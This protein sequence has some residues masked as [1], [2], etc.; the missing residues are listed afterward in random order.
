MDPTPGA[1]VYDP[2]QFPPRAV[3]VDIVVFSVRHDAP[4]PGEGRPDDRLQVLVID[5]SSDAEVFPGLLALPGSFVRDDENLIQAAARV[6]R[7]KADLEL[8]LTALEQFGA[9]GDPDR[10]PRMR[11]IS[12]GFIAR[13]DAAMVAVDEIIR[14]IAAGW[15]WVPVV[16]LIDRDDRS[17]AFDHAQILREA[18][19]Y[20]RTGVE[21]TD[22][23]LDLLPEQ[24]T[25]KQLRSTYEAIWGA[26]IDA[27]NFAKRVARLDGFIEECE[28]PEQV[29]DRFRGL[30]SPAPG[31][32]D[33][34][35]VLRSMRVADDR[36]FLSAP[37]LLPEEFAREFS[38]ESDWSPPELRRPA[39]GRGRP[40]KWFTRGSTAVLHPPLRRPGSYHSKPPSEG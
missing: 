20:L 32:E 11:V 21:E 23:A 7:E 16:E 4:A 35:P 12:I 33:H 36:I 26:P 27:G 8:P 29:V 10:D 19:E 13:V 39:R 14:E 5:R 37:R 22:A 31:V 6:L 25:L 30:E 34:P 1:E 9:Y 17:L 3:T 15:R 18:R 2:H 40:P 24:F 28:E 38:Q